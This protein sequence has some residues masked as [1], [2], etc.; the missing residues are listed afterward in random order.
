MSAQSVF[1]NSEIFQIKLVEKA[2]NWAPE[3]LIRNT[4]KAVLFHH[5]KAND[6]MHEILFENAEML[7]L[8]EIKGI[9]TT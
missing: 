2:T 5:N 6:C 1:I 8:T 3:G 4:I 9:S 7:L